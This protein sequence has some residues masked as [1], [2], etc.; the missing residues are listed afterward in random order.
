MIKSG[1]V[2]QSLQKP[3]MIWLDKTGTLTEGSLRVEEWHG[4][5]DV[6]Q[7]VA[8]LE[9]AS[10]HPV[11]KALVRF[12]KGSIG[13]NTVQSSESAG[14]G[15]AG[16]VD[17]DQ[18]VIGKLDFLKSWNI[19]PDDQQLELADG[20]ASRGLAPCWIAKNGTVVAIAAIGDAIRPEAT[21]AIE[22]LKRRGWKIGILSGDHQKI[23]T[24]VAR[25]LGID[26]ELAV[27]NV[28][29][30]EKLHRVEESATRQTVVMVGD[31]VNDS[32]A[33]AAATVGLAVKG[34]AEA[35][36]AAAPVYL[37]KPGLMPILDLF[38]FSDS[39]TRIMRR[40]LG[41][42]LAYNIGFATLAFAGFINPLVAAILMPI[43]SLT[44]VSLSLGAGR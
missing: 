8:E 13:E 40:N 29:P 36:L 24:R 31:G 26:T 17:S 42:S 19:K 39:T 41:V 25:R 21:E 11:A 43:S 34:G 35:S 15:I 22:Q 9:R 38:S 3:G 1:D 28:S 7:Q 30:E 10:N 5:A 23:V 16:Q 4:D 27:G 32:A 33:L 6:V 44:V 20:I 18:F 37:A 2:L 14:Q 12:G